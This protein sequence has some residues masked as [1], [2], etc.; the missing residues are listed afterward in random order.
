MSLPSY[1]TQDLHALWTVHE[2]PWIVML[3]LRVVIL[4]LLTPYL[5]PS[6]ACSPPAFP[7]PLGFEIWNQTGTTQLN[8]RPV[9]QNWLDKP[10]FSC[11]E[12][13]MGNMCFLPTGCCSSFRYNRKILFWTIWWSAQIP[14]IFWDIS[15]WNIGTGILNMKG[16]KQRG[17]M[18]DFGCDRE[19]G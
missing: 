7:L 13:W 19:G 4:N 15:G 17:P 2:F 11:L 18:L 10:K 16:E 1:L 5:C 9:D 14:H 8:I 12:D 6:T 3:L